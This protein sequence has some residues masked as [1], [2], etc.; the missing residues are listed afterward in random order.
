MT[1]YIE[2]VL[3]IILAI[4]TIFFAYKYFTGNRSPKNDQQILEGMKELTKGNFDVK[5]AG[6]G[7]KY[8]VYNQLVDFLN[9]EVKKE[10]DLQK[11]VEEKGV[12]LVERGEDA[13]EKADIV[14]AAMDEVGRGLNK[15]LKA[16]EE[17]SA[18]LDEMNSAISELSGRSADI[19]EQSN[20][21]LEL[22]KQ[23]NEQIQTSIDKMENLNQTVTTTYDAVKNLG[24][25]SQEIGTIAKVITDI[26]EQINLLALNAAIE[27]ARAGEHGKGFAVVADEVRKLA[28]QAKDSSDQ[29]TNIIGG[30]Q[31]ETD[32]AVQSMEQ[33]IVESQDTNNAMEEVGKLFQDILTSTQN[34]ADNNG[35]TSA[36][37]EEMSASIQQIVSSVEQVT[38]ISRESVEMFDELTEI[39]DDQI[40]TMEKLVEEAKA[41]N[42]LKKNKTSNNQD[43]QKQLIGQKD[44]NKDIAV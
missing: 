41:L 32:K 4:T 30:T 25:K 27:A 36:A 13:S 19:S 44:V 21:T 26:S 39:N 34:I 6:E 37:T 7:Q 18:A 24:E 28:E 14:R 42:D 3:I 15:Q 22:T 17:S 11:S 35:D 10:E 29:V 40:A 12:S 8:Q 33:G 1:N 43:A 23:G 9:H 16:T 38:F 5:V 20:N 2:M 31:Q